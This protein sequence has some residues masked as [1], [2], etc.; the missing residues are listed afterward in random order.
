MYYIEEPNFPSYVSPTHP[1]VS[2]LHNCKDLVSKQELEEVKLPL[3]LCVLNNV[4]HF[5]YQIMVH[6]CIYMH[7]LIDII[8]H[9]SLLGF[10]ISIYS[11]CLPVTRLSRER[12]S[13]LTVLG[14]TDLGLD[15]ILAR[16]LKLAFPP[17]VA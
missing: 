4:R 1:N 3:P 17:V 7:V 10:M 13:T 9:V 12:I 14:N 15:D 16:C 8:S 6:V 2:H 11:T 5:P